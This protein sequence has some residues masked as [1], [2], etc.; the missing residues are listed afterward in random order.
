MDA[1]KEVSVD[2]DST[3]PPPP[4]PPPGPTDRTGRVAVV[5][6]ALVVVLLVVSV[7]AR[8]GSPGPPTGAEAP[9]PAPSSSA[10]TTPSPAPTRSETPPP[11]ARDIEVWSTTAARTFATTSGRW[12]QPGDRVGG[13]AERIDLQLGTRR[14]AVVGMG[15][16]LTHSSAA[17]LAAMQPGARTAL[18][19]ELFAPS[20]PVRLGVV[21]IPLGGS[22]FVDAPAYTY[23]DLPAGDTDW[24]LDRFSTAAD[25]ATLRPILREIV[26]IAPDIRVIAAPWSPPA[27]LKTSGSLVGGELVDDPRAVPTYAR[28]LLRALTD[29]ADA[30][31]PIDALSVQNEPQLRTPDGYPGADIPAEVAIRLISELGPRIADAGLDTGLLAFDHNW[32]LGQGDVASTPSGRDPQYDYAAD[33]LRGPAAEWV[34]GVAFH[35]YSGDASRQS[36]LHNEFPDV[37]ISVTECSGSH[38]PDDTPEQIF[39]NTLT[40]QSDNL[41]IDALNNWADSVLTW[42]LALD[43]EGGPHIGGCDACT[44]VV[45]VD[46]EGTVTRNA[47]YY[48]LASV[49]RYVPPG[50][51]V[52]ETLGEEGSP[53]TRVAFETPD[54][55]HVLVVFNHAEESVD[56][57]VGVGGELARV[58]VPPQAL[59]SVVLP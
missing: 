33:V 30:G 51:V 13:P 18:L 26:A 56:L 11:A 7:F 41:V 54:G 55:S 5:S 2:E 4:P 36:E 27:W 16:A 58:T 24:N 12:V 39:R 3:A 14:Q 59:A 17:V 32:S 47:E 19:E 23:N 31:L 35:C 1:Y 21:R 40:W 20:G 52:L 38:G 34:S 28:Y 53:L 29:Y 49:A 6:V 8:Q 48:T 46:G 44:G 57:E 25:D 45:T 50:S 10:S 42:N 22:D 43:P 9:S 15:A 37:P